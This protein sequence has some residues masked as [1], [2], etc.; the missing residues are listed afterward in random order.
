MKQRNIKKSLLMLTSLISIVEIQAQE[1]DYMNIYF[2][3]E[4]LFQSI[5]I[6]EI[7]KITFTSDDEV[8][9]VMSGIVTP[10]TID[11]IEVITF[12]DANITDIE[13]SKDKATEIEIIYFREDGV[14]GITSPEPINVVQIYNMQGITM[15]TQT[16]QSQAAIL[17]VNSY[18]Q[19]IYIVAVQSNG[20][21]GI[22]KLI[23]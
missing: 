8:N 23:K 11:D 22:K 12:S 21:T 19:G 15:Q 20:K 13:E 18:P 6:D 10:M 9:I 1:V 4:G 5:S 14:I 7:D 17:D 16:P 2:T 3:S